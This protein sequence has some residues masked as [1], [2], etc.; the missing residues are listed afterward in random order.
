MSTGLL[1]VTAPEADHKLINSLLLHIRDW[2]FGSGDR[3]KLVTTK[4]AYDLED[5][6][7]KTSS[8]ATQNPD[9]T[10]PPLS[11]SPD[12]GW[13][14]AALED[15]EAFCMDLMR[16]EELGTSYHAGQF[17][18]VDS[19]D[20]Q[21]HTCILGHRAIDEE[22]ADFAY[23]DRYNKMRVPWDKLYSPWCNLDIA[24]MNF[25]EFTQEEDDGR[26]GVD[27]W[28]TFR[29]I[30]EGDDLS[31]DNRRKRDREIQRFRDAGHI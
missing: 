6:P 29:D 28:F 3:F 15:V 5:G 16:D 2:E 7:E 25:E 12:N 21:A 14:G 13:A 30:M 4:N 10:S 18:V 22:A 1:F 11:S 27:G 17:V 31:A 9:E 26:P 20:V 23:L 8:A 19:T 24:N